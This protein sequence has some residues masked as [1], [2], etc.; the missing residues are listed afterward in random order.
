MKKARKE[1]DKCPYCELGKQYKKSLENLLPKPKENSVAI[2]KLVEDLKCIQNHQDLHSK[3]TVAFKTQKKDLL[4]NQ[5]LLIIDFKENLK[6]G[7]S[8]IEVSSVFYSKVQRSVFTAVLITKQ[9]SEKKI[10]YFDFVLE[11]MS[12]NTAFV[13]DCLNI[14]FKS[15]Q[16][17]QYKLSELFVW[18]DGGPGHFRTFEYCNYMDQLRNNQFKKIQWNYFVEYHGKNLCDSHFAQISTIKRNYENNSGVISTTDSLIKVLQDGFTKTFE[19]AAY[20]DSKRAVSNHSNTSV[21]LFNYKIP[22]TKP[23]T[24][25]LL[26]KNFKCYYSFE[27]LEDGLQI[28]IYANDDK[29][30]ILPRK[31]NQ[32][33]YKPPAKRAA[34]FKI[35]EPS[36]FE[37]KRRI[38][39]RM[40]MKN[41]DTTTDMEINDDDIE[42][43]IEESGTI[44][45]EL[46]NNTQL[47]DSSF[48]EIE[49]FSISH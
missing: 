41:N 40:N 49:T 4:S 17:K 22:S 28:Q 32:I 29:K 6:L 24:Y 15:D 31:Y 34:N 5:G 3:Q 2:H 48:M 23:I 37:Y 47:S 39:T 46:E 7:G 30:I 12:H 43:I 36:L 27:S 16:F 13:I 10:H 35:E 19:N 11:I 1:T 33:E 26:I 25:Q 44:P 21:T 14:L 45:M 8:P 38:I 9:N 20:R 18:S 42:E